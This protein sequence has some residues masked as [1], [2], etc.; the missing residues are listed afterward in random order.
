MNDGPAPKRRS[1]FSVFVPYILMALTVGLFIWLIVSQTVGKPVTWTRD[2]LD[3][4]LGYSLNVNQDN[5]S[6]SKYT[7]D[8]YD[9]LEYR[10]YAIEVSQGYKAVSVTG[11][12]ANTS[13]RSV[14][15]TVMIEENLW[16]GEGAGYSIYLDDGTMVYHP[17]YE[18][19][20][21][22]RID[23]A[24]TA[25]FVDPSMCFISV[26]DG[27]A[28]S[29]WDSWGPTIILLIGTAILALFIFGRLNRSV[30]GM[31]NSAFSFNKSPARKANS[32]VRFSDV[33]GCDEEKAEMV[34]LVEYLKD[35]H[36]Y[37]KFGARL[38]KGVL[39]IGPPGTGK[40]LLAKAVAGEAG[41]PFYSIS[42]SDFVEMYVGVGAGR[43]R[44]L[45]RRAKETAPCLIFIDE[46]DAVGRQRGAGLGGGNDERE[47]TL[48][49]LLVEM[50]GFEA[51]SGILVIAAT[52]RDDVLDPAL[53]RAGRF[54]RTITV[55]LPDKAG[56]EAIFKVHARN[57]TIDSHV[58]F[59]ALAKR[60]VGFSGADIDNV[61]NEAAILAVRENKP[62]IDM[63]D[64]DEAID[65]RISGPA[66]SSRAMSAKERKEVAYHEAGHSVIGIYLPYS[67]KVQK[68]TII[69]RGNTGGHV[70][71][72]PEDD[73][74]LLTK[75]EL[76]ARITGLLGG[77]TSEEIF[78]QDVTTGAS[79]DIEQATRLARMM[80]TE[81]GM[82]ELGPI[83][84]ERDTGSVFL[85]RDY[86]S[87][88][89]NFS[90]QIA[91][92]IDKAV[93]RIIEDAHEKA[94][95]VL[96]EHKDKVILIAETLLEKE[97]ITAEEIEYLCANGTLPPVVHDPEVKEE[98]SQGVETISDEE[99]GEKA[100]EGKEA[101][102]PAS[103]K[104]SEP[105]KGGDNQ[106]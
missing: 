69:P 10:V 78:F 63:A 40:T 73:R 49:Q 8:A 60:T 33:A 91:F 16:S 52:N 67:D 99:K 9:T 58:D 74:F 65:R 3:D 77:R 96:L 2:Q 50:D 28:V 95:Q 23:E 81:F 71:M 59:A 34:E 89:R 22:A 104:P 48:N 51:N 88:Q 46:I 106:A 102:E 62:A 93:R 18:A 24:K 45:F 20:F 80:V 92:E 12:A 98:Q 4:Y 103:E 97:T 94:R 17:Y 5:P 82:S 42:G 83:Q 53:R 54:D 57:K 35:P 29:W 105:D 21:T 6:D 19:M 75:N 7:A 15:F 26:V 56:R 44:D 86:A 27:F 55:S 30:S 32:K 72:T 85:G 68:I 31:N 70:L 79:N 25:G 39:L 14:L 61:L 101:S 13:N 43:V 84:Y 90:T 11:R 41:A 1:I 36:K 100:A 66:K 47:Q 76:I 38:P 37:S 64:I 87:T